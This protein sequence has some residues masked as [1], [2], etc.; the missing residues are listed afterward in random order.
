MV[1]AFLLLFLNLLFGGC[2]TVHSDTSQEGFGSD[3]F[4]PFFFIHAG[5]PQIG[6]AARLGLGSIEEDK[7]RFI[8]LAKR[9][10]ELDCPFILV[11]G[12]LVQFFYGARPDKKYGTVSENIAAF[13]QA[14][15]QFKVPVKLV[16]GNHEIHDLYQLKKYR[17][18][19]G[20]DYYVFTY[21][22]CDF[23]CLN[24][25]NL[26]TGSRHVDEQVQQTDQYKRELESQWQW[27]ENTLKKSRVQSRNHIFILKHIPPFT[28]TEDEDQTYHSMHPQSRKR[29]L[30][31]IREYGVKVIMA[32]HVHKTYELT[33]DDFTI[34][35]VGG[36]SC[37]FDGKG[38]GYRI[39]K[40]YKDKIE[41][42]YVHID[43]CVEKVKL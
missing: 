30:K 20:K 32:G 11:A 15:Q 35:T 18:N 17:E 33:T 42:E 40:V 16:P 26:E 41:Q 39:F 37:V 43:Q 28:Q 31:L 25:V 4:K 5:D 2:K 13:D 1:I 22:N 7:D 23:I 24:S 36:T 8:Q 14:L 19:Y 3:K 9:V 27:L 34:Y 10:N 12:D 29:F 21:N 6:M 38:F